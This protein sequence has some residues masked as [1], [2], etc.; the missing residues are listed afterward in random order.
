MRSRASSNA[1]LYRARSRCD[2]LHPRKIGRCK[3][4]A[5]TRGLRG[6]AGE[7]TSG[8]PAHSGASLAGCVANPGERVSTRSARCSDQVR[9]LVTE[10][11]DKAA[12]ADAEPLP[13]GQPVRCAC[14]WTRNSHSTLCSL[15]DT[16]A[17]AAHRSKISAV[18]LLWM[19]KLP[20]TTPLGRAPQSAR[21][22]AGRSRGH[23]RSVIAGRI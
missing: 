2:Q 10:P 20:K 1:T 22:G 18:N 14:A 16:P 6:F 11:P 19:L 13:P 17:E 12:A 8:N 4:L 5:A 15:F 23:G 9:S 21:V 7:V 3:T